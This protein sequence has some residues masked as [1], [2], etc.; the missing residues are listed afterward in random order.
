MQVGRYE[1]RGELGRG[2]MG[3]VYRAYDPQLGREV[4]L[5][6]LL[7]AVED[8]EERARFLNEGRTAKGVEHPNVLAVH[9]MGLVEGRLFLAMDLAEGG[10]LADRLREHGA[11]PAREAAGV[12]AQVARGLG[13]LHAARILHRDL[14]PE[15][16]LFQAGRPVLADFGLA[17]ALDRETRI[18]QTGQMLGTPS[19]M[20]PEQARGQHTEFGP[21][22]DVYGLGA[23]L[24]Q[25]LCGQPPFRGASLLDLLDQIVN[26]A[27]P[28]LRGA[29]PGVD[30]ALEAICLRCLAKDPAQRYPSAGALADALDE[31]L[32]REGGLAK[33]GGGVW[34]GL[35]VV[36]LV[37]LGGLGVALARGVTSS[38]PAQPT[39]T[40]AAPPQPRPTPTPAEDPHSGPVRLE[41]LEPPRP[42]WGQDIELKL[43]LSGAQSAHIRSGSE[44]FGEFRE[45]EGTLVVPL[46][47]GVNQRL[48]LRPVVEGEQA[49]EGV[50]L[51]VTRHRAP[52]WFLY[53]P[54]AARPPT[55]PPWLVILEQPPGVYRTRSPFKLLQVCWVPGG[56]VEV[57]DEKG[58]GR[59][60][61][62]EGVFV[63]RDEVH[64]DFFA[65]FLAQSGRRVAQE[66]TLAP[67][68]VDW[69]AAAAYARWAGGRLPSEAEWCL[70]AYGGRGRSR[71]YPWGD[72][73]PRSVGA[74][75]PEAGA[76]ARKLVYDSHQDVTPDGVRGLGGNVR[77]WVLERFLPLRP[78]GDPWGEVPAWPGPGVFPGLVRGGSFCSSG[79]GRRGRSSAPSAD[80]FEPKFGH[81]VRSPPKG[82]VGF[83]VVLDLAGRSRAVAR[84]LRWK[85]ELSRFELRG[86]GQPY[87]PPRPED[88]VRLPGRPREIE[89]IDFSPLGTPWPRHLRGWEQV[90]QE[91]PF[92]L[93]ATGKVKLSAGAWGVATVSDDGVRLG[94]RPAGSREPFRRLI[95][96]YDE[97][98][99]TLDRA[100]FELERETRVEFE[101]EYY[102]G[103]GGSALRFEFFPLPH[104]PSVD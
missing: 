96:R 10:S 87:P 83:R 85:V 99:A 38:P 32:R 75:L 79:A 25:C 17:R 48:E 9:G 72:Q 2:A 53:L 49:G 77:E 29:A 82:D 92:H 81:M 20:A 33:S 1:V 22:T 65:H 76:Q 41:L 90:P 63:G 60:V 80:Y 67:A 56:E 31:W 11:L 93:R 45:G 91:G 62:V 100:R 103:V 94:W 37:A 95:D 51:S 14:K 69:L 40:S 57:L 104:H 68:P 61:R 86:E 78:Q 66:M 4:A 52:E 88:L 89:A 6:A 44:G 84:K 71:P 26:A 50:D 8:E 102:N 59:V 42:T 64:G 101:L 39:S 21:A 5:K 35:G 55:I 30:P 28:P 19:Y 54:R 16:V 23:V 36:L 15:N 97:H 47:V 24:Y 73:T 3:V 27:P 43:R 70:A 13:A 98:Y 12:I 46:P 58:K 74:V 18:T 34:V 7:Q